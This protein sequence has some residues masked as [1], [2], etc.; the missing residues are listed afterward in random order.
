MATTKG[1]YFYM[2]SFI[3]TAH[4]SNEFAVLRPA[5][6]D[7]DISGINSIQTLLS[8]R[9]VVFFNFTLNTSSDWLKLLKALC[10][11]DCDWSLFNSFTVTGQ[12]F[13]CVSKS[14]SSM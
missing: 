8:Y 14:V 10:N 5:D 6:N 7:S 9:F 4:Q 12:R 13:V 2:P 1:L 11:S 3:F